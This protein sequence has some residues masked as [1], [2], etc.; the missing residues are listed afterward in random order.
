MSSS[1]GTVVVCCRESLSHTLYQ[2]TLQWLYNNLHI[3]AGILW[4]NLPNIKH[5]TSIWI[6][7]PHVMLCCCLNLQ[8]EDPIIYIV[9]V[10]YCWSVLVLCP[11]CQCYQFFETLVSIGHKSYTF[12]LWILP[13]KQLTS[14]LTKAHCKSLNKE[15]TLQETQ[16][17]LPLK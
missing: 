1:W 12:L 7:D 10:K 9:K 8:G 13:Q 2:S 3:H 4:I 5:V 11:A 16:P 15:L 6:A 17:T 14:S